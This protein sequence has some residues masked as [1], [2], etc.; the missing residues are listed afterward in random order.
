ME[1]KSRYEV[2]AEL[3]SNKRKLIQE[4]DSL[5]DKLVEKEKE[6]RNSERQKSDT[7][8]VLDRRIEDIKEDIENFKKTM[9]ERKETIKELI[10]SVDLSLERFNQQQK[11]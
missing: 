9:A 5:N 11:Q 10:V 8:V 2:I 4:R 7:I 3:E 1:T 6:L